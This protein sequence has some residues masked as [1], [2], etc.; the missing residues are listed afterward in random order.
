MKLSGLQKFILKKTLE[1][2]AHKDRK[3][4]VSRQRFYQFYQ[5]QKK[6]PNKKVQAN[7]ITRSLER[8]ID[9]G[10]VIGYGEKTQYKLFINTIKLTPA[11]KKMTKQ[12]FGRQASLPF[13]KSKSTR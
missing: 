2:T 13:G 1:D 9:R 6:V 10:L 12:L 8:L 7:I 3:N 4:I 5:S 11:G